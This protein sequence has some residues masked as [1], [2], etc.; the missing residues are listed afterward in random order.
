MD[1][2]LSIKMTPMGMDVA[3]LAGAELRIKEIFETVKKDGGGEDELVEALAKEADINL[4]A[5]DGFISSENDT[6]RSLMHPKEFLEANPSPDDA[7][8]DDSY[9]A[10]WEEGTRYGIIV[11]VL[12]NKKMGPL[13]MADRAH[14]FGSGG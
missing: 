9:I 13:Q 1:D 10:G 2:R 12:F 3:R 5:L 8:P 4:D 11:G 14:R 6:L 7:D